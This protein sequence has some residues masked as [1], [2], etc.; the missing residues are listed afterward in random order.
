MKVFR[1][2]WNRKCWCSIL[3][4]SL[5]YWLW[6]RGSWILMLLLFR[7]L[8]ISSIVVRGCLV[9]FWIWIH[10]WGIFSKEKCWWAFLTLSERSSDLIMGKEVSAVLLTIR[11]TWGRGGSLV[12]L[13]L[14]LMLIFGKMLIHSLD[15]GDV[16]I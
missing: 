14:S 13:S 12:W 16:N 3:I 6:V 15:N 1:S 10:S 8:F 5:K 2:L 7:I 4:W 9:V 11:K